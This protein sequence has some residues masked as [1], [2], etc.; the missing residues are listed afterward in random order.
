MAILAFSLDSSFFHQVFLCQSTYLY[1]TKVCY[2]IRRIKYMFHEEG[3]QTFY[4]R[5]RWLHSPG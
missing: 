2:D 5:L 1:L 3:A 4:L